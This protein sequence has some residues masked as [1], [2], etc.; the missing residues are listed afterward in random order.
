MGVGLKTA[1]RM[2]TRTAVATRRKESTSSRGSGGENFRVAVRVRPL[3]ERELKSGAPQVS[4]RL[5]GREAVGDAVSKLLYLQHM[6]DQ[7][8]ECIWF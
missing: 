2:A 6:H 8:V 5:Q 3:I 7:S 4:L 1:A